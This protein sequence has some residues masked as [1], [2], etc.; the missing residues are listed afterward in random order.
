MKRILKRL[1]EYIL[2]KRFD[3]IEEIIFSNWKAIDNQMDEIIRLKNSNLD[4]SMKLNSLRS[5]LKSKEVTIN[6]LKWKK[7]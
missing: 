1:A 2:R 7:V 5:T 3:D 6:R 4:K